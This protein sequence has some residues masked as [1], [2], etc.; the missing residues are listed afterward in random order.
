MLSYV[1]FSWDRFWSI[2]QLIYDEYFN[3]SNICKS[4]KA[5]IMN[6]LCTHYPNSVNIFSIF[7]SDFSFIEINVSEKAEVPCV[8]L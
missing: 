5:N 3:I 6:N 4:L 1:I 2:F 7:A 8:L